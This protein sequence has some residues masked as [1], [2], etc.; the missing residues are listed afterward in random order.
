MVERVPF[1]APPT[2]LMRLANSGTQLLLT[3]LHLDFYTFLT[4]FSC[5]PA[6]PSYH[7]DSTVIRR[8]RRELGG[9]DGSHFGGEGKARDGGDKAGTLP[10]T[11]RLRDFCAP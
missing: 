3:F 10:R 9:R 2:P 8:F 11:G 1:Y 5:A 7:L 6:I 4:T